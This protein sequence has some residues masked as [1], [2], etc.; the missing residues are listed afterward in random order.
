MT[1][2]ATKDLS[3]VGTEELHQRLGRC[4]Q[5]TSDALTEAAAIWS[6]L[7]RRGE[8]PRVL[9]GIAQWLPRLSRGD[10]S[11]EAVIAFAGIPAVLSRLT[12]M[13][14]DLQKKLADGETIPIAVFN[15]DGDAVAENKPLCQLSHREILLAIEGGEIRPISAQIN[16]LKRGRSAVRA[17][18][19]YASVTIKADHETGMLIIG[20]ARIKPEEEMAAL[21]EL[22]WRLEKI[23]PRRKSHA[24]A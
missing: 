5:V 18:G 13:A 3:K 10:L 6:E 1:N 19:P 15:E 21:R 12:G 24:R 4:L 7:S 8:A 22:G 16:S 11:A 17:T 14:L 23:E 2:V 20:R 9:S